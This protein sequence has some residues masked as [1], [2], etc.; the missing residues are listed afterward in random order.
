MTVACIVLGGGGHARVV[1]DLLRESGDASV[2]GVLERDRERRGHEVL[3]APILGGDE[4]L[5]RLYQ[6]GVRYFIVGLGSVGDTGPRRRLFE[7]GVRHGLKPVRAIHPRAYVSQS[8]DV[9]E[10]TVVLA[11]AV[12]NA[13][14]RIGA[15]VIVNTGAIVEHDC[16]L[17]DHVHVATGAR[18]AGTVLVAE[19]AHIGIGATIIQGRQIGER[20]VVGAGAVVLEDVRAG[21]VVAGV[22]AR[23]VRRRDGT[24]AHHE[25]SGHGA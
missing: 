20:A 4:L 18:L 22:P 21:A 17:G 8:A 12:V 10:G 24:E 5:P 3:G 7:L 16:V 19:G 2:H 23:P 1:I 6:D 14:A 15:N 13:G 25:G 9:G 11:S